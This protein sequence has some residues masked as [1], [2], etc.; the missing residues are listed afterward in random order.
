MSNIQAELG[1]LQAVPATDE[2]AVLCLEGEFDRASAPRIVE[3]GECILRDGKHLIV[4]ISATT[5]IDSSAVGALFD[6]AAQAEKGRRVAV[7]QLGTAAIVERVLELMEVDQVLPRAKT[8]Q[9]AIE[10]VKQL[11]SPRQASAVGRLRT[12]R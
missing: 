8:R 4:D 9:E 5:F 6:I 1:V 11:V 10:T 7:M 3:E 12:R 2:I